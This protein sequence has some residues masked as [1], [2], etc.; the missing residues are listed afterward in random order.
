MTRQPTT[1]S[2][3][4]PGAVP[5]DKE[6]RGVRK[7][8][9]GTQLW[10][11]R[12]PVTVFS[13]AGWVERPMKFAVAVHGTR[14][15]VEPCAAVCLEL[16]SR[17]H[18]V[19]LAVPPNL[20]PF[21][22]TAGLSPAVP[23]GVDS[24]QQLDADIFRRYWKI[25]N[26]VTA[27]RELREY[28]TQ[29][30]AEMSTTLTSMADGAD[31]ILTGTTYQEVAANVA[32]YYRIPLAALHYFPARANSQALPLPLPSRLIL[33]AWMLGEWVHWRTL[34]AAEDAQRRRL[35]LPRARVRA[36]RRIVE[37]GAL[38]IQAYD[39]VFYPTLS[40]EWRG[41]RPLVG[42]MTLELS[43]ETDDEIA[44]W[45]AAGKPPVYFGFGS[46]PVESPADAVA[47]IT[48]VCAELGE[49]ALICT[50]VWNLDN[51]PRAD[52]VKLV[53]TVN[54]A[55]VFPIC[56]AV[57]HHGGSGTTA[58]GVRAGVPTLI[59]WVGADQPLWGTQIERLKVGKSLRFSRIT[60]DSL[61]VA[62]RSV[63]A[64]QYATRAREVATQMTKP[65]ASVSRTADLL[66]EAVRK[67]R[68]R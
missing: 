45:I 68:G 36:I 55:A 9:V 63:L 8:C 6:Q 15:D 59:L 40:A 65:A 61:L 39:E 5:G 62:L 19:R 54:H 17:G 60:R 46:M 20:V 22:E 43:T 41:S 7:A 11:F 3:V 29:G 64:L 52:H 56:R 16:L 31:L 33:S 4:V 28:I 25:Q 47:M 26:P 48:E 2:F 24:Q 57:V 44:S 21:V 34:K 53:G 27:L 14:G 66:E 13:L 32:E 38:E 23:Y 42:S 51:T 10:R 49:R 37:S 58:A 50:G 1:G 67:R 30:W 12:A 18:D 35:G